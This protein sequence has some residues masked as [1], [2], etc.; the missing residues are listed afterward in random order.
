MKLSNPYWIILAFCFY[1]VSGIGPVKGEPVEFFADKNSIYSCSIKELPIPI[2]PS[3]SPIELESIHRMGSIIYAS[4]SKQITKV[5]VEDLASKLHFNLD[6]DALLVYQSKIYIRSGSPQ[7]F[8]EYSTYAGRRSVAITSIASKD[9]L[10]SLSI[11]KDKM[12]AGADCTVID[13]HSGADIATFRVN[14][15]YANTIDAMEWISDRYVL[16]ISNA[17]R[18]NAAFIIDTQS[19]SP[20]ARLLLGDYF[21]INGAKI[22]VYTKATD[23]TYSLQ[24]ITL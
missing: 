10:C 22:E 8:K 18:G 11:P 7:L 21:T 12:F 16:C 3:F 20:I 13:V 17:P 14:E 9:R 2:L 1:E 4:S 24:E 15:V 23:G 6:F 5:A 19:Q